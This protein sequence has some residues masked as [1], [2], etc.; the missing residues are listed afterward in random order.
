MR[1]C[2]EC[3][4]LFQ[5][6]SRHLRC[7]ACRA[8]TTCVCGRTKQAKSAR[9][10]QCR[11]D[12]NEINGNWKEGQTRHKKGCIMVLAPDHPR[13]VNSRYV[14]EHILGAEA[15]LGRYLEPGESVHHPTEFG[16]TTGRRIW[17][18]GRDRNRREFASAT[19]LRGRTRFSIDMKLGGA[20]HLQ[21]CSR[22]HKHSWRWRESNPRL[23]CC[24]RGFSERSRQGFLGRPPP[25]GH[26]RRPSLAEVSR[27]ATRRLPTVSCS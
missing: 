26:D 4:R 3:A 1:L 24:R 15:V 11:N 27:R 2:A 25:V 16:T 17:S 19:R 14:F 10:A 7:P 18:S 12:A 13:A 23:P 5:P 21:Q 20:A 22:T 6:S 8:R 9:C